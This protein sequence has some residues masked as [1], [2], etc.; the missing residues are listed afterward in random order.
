MTRRD[1]RQ[2]LP[3]ADPLSLVARIV[4]KLNTVWL[5]TI[6]PFAGFGRGVSVHYSCDVSRVVS[7]YIQLGDRVYLAR[8]VWLNVEGY[9]ESRVPKIVLAKGCK[10]GR[11]S[12]ISAKKSIRLDEDV[13]LAPSVLIMDHNHE[14]GDIERP[15][16]DQGVSCGGEITIEQNCWLG[17]GAA[18]V[19]GSGELRIG[20]NSVIGAGSVV[21]R[22]FP[23]YSVI[24]GNPARLLKSYDARTGK[25]ATPTKIQELTDGGLPTSLSQA[26]RKA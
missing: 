20:R 15:I 9:T 14:F 12:T 11:R 6:Y 4:T 21:T 24:V 26:T 25:W 3:T 17:Y 19:C 16:H 1:I 13:L 7:P 5:S 23:P 2:P 22:S 8:D 10:I 18:V